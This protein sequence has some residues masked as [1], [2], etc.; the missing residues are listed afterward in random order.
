MSPKIKVALVGCVAFFLLLAGILSSNLFYIK[1]AQV[2]G[3][4]KHLVHDDVQA[5]ISELGQ[6]SLFSS[7]HGLQAKLM[8]NPWIRRV[9]IQ[10]NWP[11]TLSIYVFEREPIANW[12]EQ[13]FMDANGE[14]YKPP[15]YQQD[16]RLPSIESPDESVNGVF[17][18]LQ[19][20]A[21]NAAEGF[22]VSK[23]TCAEWGAMQIIFQNNV[24]VKLG[25]HDVLLRLKKFMKIIKKNKFNECKGKS[26]AFDMR[27]AKGF[28]LRKN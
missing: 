17:Q 1:R 7:L 10:R 8:Q 3:Q 4:N 13:E 14:I 15:D 28:T 20:L 23:I 22:V 18:V 27:Y 21:K 11:D 16:K 19:W 24:E 26:C 12:G 9:D 25:R 5:G 2:I 6:L